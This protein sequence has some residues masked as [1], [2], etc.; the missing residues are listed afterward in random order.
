METT[1]LSIEKVES[2]GVE[3]GKC[4]VC[5]KQIMLTGT[6]RSIWFDG[7]IGGG[8]EVRFVADAY[9][10]K[11]DGKPKLLLYGTP[12]YESEIMRVVTA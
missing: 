2:R 7:M 8:G 11:C 10:P 12:I 5:G 6:G 1:K 4:K 9:C 3:N